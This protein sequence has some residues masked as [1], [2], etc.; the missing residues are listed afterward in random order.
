[1]IYASQAKTKK[2]NPLVEK[3]GKRKKGAEVSEADFAAI[4]QE[5]T[6]TTI[7]GLVEEMQKW[8]AGVDAAT[9]KEK[10]QPEKQN[11]GNGG[12]GRK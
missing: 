10:P 6:E 3:F 4:M 9:E 11:P 2:L 12:M 1:M 5:A 7:N 8:K